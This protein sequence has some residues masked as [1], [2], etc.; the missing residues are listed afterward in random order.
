MRK[1]LLTVL[2]AL[3][4]A[5]LPWTTSS[6]QS[7]KPVSPEAFR[8]A[9]VQPISDT[10]IIAEAEEFQIVSAGWKAKPFGTNYYAATFANSFLSRKAYLGAPEQCPN[11]IAEITVNVPKA[12]KYLALVRYEACY[13]FE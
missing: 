11:C 12:G 1:T 9:P 13:R 4:L 10:T 8:T 3:A 6:P 2:V 7:T 5:L